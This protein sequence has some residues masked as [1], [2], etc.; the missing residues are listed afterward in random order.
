MSYSTK[1]QKAPV[2]IK[3]SPDIMFSLNVYLRA[4]VVAEDNVCRLAQTTSVYNMFLLVNA[5]PPLVRTIL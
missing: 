3:A 1:F 2:S 5:S 4:S